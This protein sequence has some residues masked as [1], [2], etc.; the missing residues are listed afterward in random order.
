VAS[1]L[2]A[3]VANGVENIFVR[4]TCLYTT[5]STIVCTPTTALASRAQGTSSPAANGKSIMPAISADGHTVGFLSFANNLVAG[6][7]NGLEDIF[8]AATTF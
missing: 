5:S 2:G 3:N 6:D 7:T 1:N 4:N 8:L